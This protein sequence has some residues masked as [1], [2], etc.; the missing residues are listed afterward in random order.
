MTMAA[1]IKNNRGIDVGEELPEE[2]LSGIY[3][4]EK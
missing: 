3:D 1:F 2:L 4:P